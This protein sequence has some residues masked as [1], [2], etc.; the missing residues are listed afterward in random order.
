M[1]VVHATNCK[2]EDLSSFYLL[3]DEILD[4]ATN[5]TSICWSFFLVGLVIRWLML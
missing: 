3:V 4:L 2:E 1:N 5:F